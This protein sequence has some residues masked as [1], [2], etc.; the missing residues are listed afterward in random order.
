MQNL[1]KSYRIFFFRNSKNFIHEVSVPDEDFCKNLVEQTIAKFQSLHVLVNFAGILTTGKLESTPLA[2]YD[3]VMNINAR[4]IVA[5]TQFAIPH[6]K[7]HPGKASI[8]NV[9]SVNGIR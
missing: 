3:N 6:L 1:R 4:S 8:V 7:K 2:V 5:L 9:S